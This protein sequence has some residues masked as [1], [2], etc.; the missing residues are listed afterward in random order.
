MSAFKVAIVA[1]LA[2]NAVYFTVAG[3][4]SEALDAGAWLALL[5]LF[6]VETA[7]PGWLRSGPRRLLVR[8]ARLAAAGAVVAA[9][10]G[11]L[12]EDDLLD[13]VNSALWIAVV[14]LLEVEVRLPQ[15][16]ARAPRAF[17][18]TAATLYSSLGLLVIVWAASGA[19]FDAYDAALWLIAFAA[20]ELDV[21]RLTRD[22]TRP[23][24]PA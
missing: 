9:A 15:T 5:I 11:H 22:R 3:T 21:L 4:A 1:L 12:Y 8:A 17:V 7:Y 10:A 6:E 23:E 13:A 2:V 16:V 20:L 18:M 24:T 19:W 14:L